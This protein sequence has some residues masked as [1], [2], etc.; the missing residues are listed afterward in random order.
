MVAD[1]ELDHPLSMAVFDLEAEVGLF[2][3]PLPEWL[4]VFEVDVEGIGR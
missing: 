3:G 4:E 2:K 1:G